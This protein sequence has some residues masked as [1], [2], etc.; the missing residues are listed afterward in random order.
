LHPVIALSPT[1]TLLIAT[2][3][4]F[5]HNNIRE[6]AA[7]IEM[8]EDKYYYAYHYFWKLHNVFAIWKGV[9]PICSPSDYS[10]VLV[11]YDRHSK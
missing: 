9:M 7:H 10:T 5:N 8:V 2:V 3:G 4:D 11:A 1:T 6:F